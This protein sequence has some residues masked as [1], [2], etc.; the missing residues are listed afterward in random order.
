MKCGYEFLVE[1]A[2]AI[3][4]NHEKNCYIG[5]FNSSDLIKAVLMQI[6][7]YRH[8]HSKKDNILFITIN[9]YRGK[10]VFV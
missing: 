7:M 6:N 3:I 9:T 4:W 10:N 1:V 5:V 2:E 8:D